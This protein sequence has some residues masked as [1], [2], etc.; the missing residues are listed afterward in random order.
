MFSEVVKSRKNFIEGLSR[1]SCFWGFPKVMGATYGA[2]YL[3][4]KPLTLD[5]MVEQV[6]VSKG[7]VSTNVR[8]LERLGMVR[9]HFTIG[10]RKDY[11]TAET[12]FS[13]I[14]KGILRIRE[15]VEFDRAVCTVVDSLEM[16]N[17]P[18]PNKSEAEL[19]A[20]YQ[21]RMKDMKS[22][23]DSVDRLVA[24]IIAVDK[25]NIGAIEKLFGKIKKK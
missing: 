10:D 8:S 11:Y 19:V 24:A 25:L 23:F 16:L 3:S 17:A 12:D 9:K 21:E 6:G 4:P 2:L 14:V 1:I 18:N 15:K 20:F 22:F 13:K 7:S 5:D